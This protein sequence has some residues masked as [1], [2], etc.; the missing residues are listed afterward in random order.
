MSSLLSVL[1]LIASLYC[2]PPAMAGRFAYLNILRKIPVKRL[3]KSIENNIVDF[4]PQNDI[5]LPQSLT[6]ANK[7]CL[8]FVDTSACNLCLST[9]YQR[10]LEKQKL[11]MT[12]NYNV[13]LYSYPDG[14]CCLVL[15]NTT[16]MSG[17]SGTSRS[18]SPVLFSAFSMLSVMAILSLSF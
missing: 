10:H 5:V 14:N 12:L 4:I 1:L 18:A 16:A 2:W 3:R 17:S 13:V 8:P 6:V 9:L 15:S 11:N 7:S